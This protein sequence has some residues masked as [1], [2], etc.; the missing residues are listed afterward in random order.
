MKSIPAHPEHP[1]LFP[2]EARLSPSA[3]RT[4][5]G[6]GAV[7]RSREAAAFSLIELLIAILIASLLG[8]VVLYL[9][10]QTQ[11]MVRTSLSTASVAATAAVM[12]SRLRMDVASLLGPNRAQDAKGGCLV[13]VPALRLGY[14]PL[15]NGRMSKNKV[16]LRCDQLVFMSCRKPE[17]GHPWLS[18]IPPDRNTV[19]EAGAQPTDRSSWE[20]R[21]WYGALRDANASPIPDS[22][23]NPY[24]A[25]HLWPVGRQ[26]K[27]FVG[28]HAA[29]SGDCTVTGSGDTVAGT[30]TAFKDAAVAAHWTD[31][32]Y[33]GKLV[34]AGIPDDRSDYTNQPA[35][36]AR[37][38][39]KALERG[40]AEQGI[41][42]GADVIQNTLKLFDHCSEIVVQWSGDLDKDGR[43]DVYPPGHPLADSV[44]WYPEELHDKGAWFNANIAPRLDG[45]TTSPK[46]DIGA[47]YQAILDNPWPWTFD[48]SNTTK[49]GAFKTSVW[50]FGGRTFPA[51]FQFDYGDTH[52]TTSPQPTGTPSIPA[53]YVF[54]F[55]DDQFRLVRYGFRQDGSVHA[56]QWNGQPLPHAVGT[57]ANGG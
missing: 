41:Q 14:I 25:A 3:A 9:F 33:L 27:L 39:L 21:I 20:A 22:P 13:I 1:R 30:L 43:V 42:F 28:A 18:L 32:D 5:H 36:N 31:A 19:T 24:W 37:V 40:Q 15:A 54:K 53:P 52:H 47:K 57:A 12:D 17:L 50:C 26:A 34:G 49:G 38:D 16:R 6:R 46:T 4:A 7:P 48:L 35:V 44:I 8:G 55:D 56:N 29:T 10:G 11:R 23:D 45:W 51:G 2:P